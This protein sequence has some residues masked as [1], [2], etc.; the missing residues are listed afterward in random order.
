MKI[1][2]SAGP[3]QRVGLGTIECS[4]GVFLVYVGVEGRA[5]VD[6][7]KGVQF[8]L[9]ELGSCSVWGLGRGLLRCKC[10]FLSYA[11][12]VRWVRDVFHDGGGRLGWNWYSLLLYAVRNFVWFGGSQY[13]CLP[14]SVPRRGVRMRGW[15]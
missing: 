10:V 7:R 4:L 12:V 14:C 11:C 2:V 9:I 13:W 1:R 3:K 15:V 5:F 8:F 6:W